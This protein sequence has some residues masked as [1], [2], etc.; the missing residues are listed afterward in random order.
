MET[1][2]S[3][4]DWDEPLW[5]VRRLWGAWR[6]WLLFTAQGA[7]TKSLLHKLRYYRRGEAE[8]RARGSKR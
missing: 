5:S 6:H 4:D 3:D 8:E 7:C 2:G 1:G